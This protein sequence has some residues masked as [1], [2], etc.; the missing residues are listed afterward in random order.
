MRNSFFL[1]KFGNNLGILTKS[2]L[3][4]FVALSHFLIFSGV[5]SSGGD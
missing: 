4:C 1:Y 2:K 3:M 5:L